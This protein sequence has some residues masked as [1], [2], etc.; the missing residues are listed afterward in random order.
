MLKAL[1]DEHVHHA[2][3]QALRRRGVDVVTVQDR[4]QRGAE[5]I[6]LLRQA[7]QEQRVMLT[8]DHHFLGLAA[9]CAAKQ[10]VFAPIFYW[11]QQRRTVGEMVRR[12]IREASRFSYSD[13]CSQVFFL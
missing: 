4:G 10:E 1:A 9:Q 11:Q 2:I 13:V 5:D 7:L 8:N 12:I 3:V 6:V